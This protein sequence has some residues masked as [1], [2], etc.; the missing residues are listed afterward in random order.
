[1]GRDFAKGLFGL[2]FS[3]AEFSA[4]LQVP[5]LGDLLGSREAFFLADAPVLARQMLW[6][7]FTDRNRL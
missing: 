4:Q 1:M 3:G 6:R 5:V 7:D 2:D